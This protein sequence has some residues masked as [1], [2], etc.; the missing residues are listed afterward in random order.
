MRE[1]DIANQRFGRLVAVKRVENVGRK[2]FWQVDCDCGTS[3]SMCLDSIKKSKS[4]GCLVAE[5]ARQRSLKHGHAVDYA[6]S[7][8]YKSWAGAKGRCFNPSDAKFANYG[9]L[10]ITMS[11][12]WATDFRNFLRD[13]GECPKGKT[14]G[15]IDVG[16]GYRADNCRWETNDQQARA[17][18]DNVFVEHD[19]QRLVLKDFAAVNSVPYKQLHARVKYHGQTPQEAVLH[20]R[21][22]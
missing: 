16:K 19:G 6:A 5:T 1:V 2:T 22:R 12:D 11:E 21:S 7:K 15:R 4:C 18:T 13:M 8:T 14:L 17:R 9:A 20:I 3:R 10:G